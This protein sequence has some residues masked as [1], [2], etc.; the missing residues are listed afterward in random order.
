MPQRSPGTTRRRSRGGDF[1]ITGYATSHPHEDWA[2]TLAHLMHLT[3]ILDSAAASGLSWPEGP[4]LPYDAYAEA[5]TERLVTLAIDLTLAI[6]HVNRALDLP[7]LYP[8]VLAAPV[9]EK[10]AFAHGALRI[11]GPA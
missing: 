6:N 8:F 10:L 1:H 9:R 2:E 4:P 7:D 11:G 3:D 5:D